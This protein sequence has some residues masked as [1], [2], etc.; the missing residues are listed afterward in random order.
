[1][2]VLEII[3]NDKVY[4]YQLANLFEYRKYLKQYKKATVADVW[5]KNG[6]VMI[7]IDVLWRG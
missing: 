2:Y 5:C 4:E 7:A 1:M 6:G 3:E